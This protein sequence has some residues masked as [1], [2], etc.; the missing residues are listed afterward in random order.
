MQLLVSVRSAD[1]VE[2]ALAGGAD[3]IDAK[4]P[5]RGS[6]GPVDHSTLRQIIR[7][8]TGDCALSIALGDVTTTA[9]VIA[10]FQGLELSERVS[11]TYLKF[12]FAGVASSEAIGLLLETAVSAGRTMAASPLVVAVAYADSERAGTVSPWV[13]SSLAKSAGAA[14]VLLDTNGKGD[15]GLLDWVSAGVL[16]EWVGGVR[17]RGLLAGVA[18]S[19]REQDLV[20]VCPAQPDVLGIRGAACT[21][22]RTGRVSAQRVRQFRRAMPQAEIA[23]YPVR[24]G[25]QSS[26]RNA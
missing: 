23:G 21:G 3:I 16:I 19:L 15:G 1:E 6:L 24:G 22:G 18:G 14:G 2:A 26:S 11:P 17:E 4:E 10:A 7:S 20:L 13:I 5:D 8:A 12:G 25:V 9:D